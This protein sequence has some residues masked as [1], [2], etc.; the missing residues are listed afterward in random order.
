VDLLATTTDPG[1]GDSQP[2]GRDLSHTHTN[3]NVQNE[4]I[5]SRLKINGQLLDFNLVKWQMN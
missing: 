3:K 1:K 2:L 5:Y 4:L